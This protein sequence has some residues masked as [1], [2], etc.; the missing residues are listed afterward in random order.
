MLKRGTPVEIALL[1][2]GARGELNLATLAKRHPDK[3]RF[4]AVAEPHEGRR[5][6]FI[7]NFGIPRNR[8]FTGW[9]ELLDRPRLADGVINAL[10]CHMHYDSTLA[11]LAAG[12]HIFLE[13]PMA[14]TPRECIHLLNRARETGRVLMVATQSRYNKIYTKMI[15]QVEE[16]RIG[17]MMNID[18]CEDIGYW[19]FILSYVRGIHHRSDQSHSFII[20]KG[21]H[22]LDLVSWY[23]GAPAKRVA[24]FGRLSFF[25]SENAPPGAAKRCLDDCPAEP[26]C[27]FS[28]RKQFLK[29]GRPDIP[30]SLFGGMSLEALKDVI[31]NPR[32]RTLASV[33]T[34]DI[35]PANR[36]KVLEDT[37]NGQCVFHCDN[38]VVDHQTVSIEFENGVTASFSLSGFSLIWERT[39]NLH[40]TKGELRSKDFSGLLERRTYMPAKVH[41]ERVRFHG[42]IHG[43]GDEII[44]LEFA[45]AVKSGNGD[46]I[47]TGAET[48][49][50]SH[51]ICFAAEEARRQKKVVDMAE[52]RKLAALAKG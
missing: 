48:S 32:F 7:R 15:K 21:I 33:I 46:K 22:D 45:K 13:K 23:A 39:L 4:V 2:A 5:E 17:R 16:G 31:V 43:G 30:I 10:P 25:N 29:P 36:R 26:N 28:A 49:V 24:S 47:L 19:H 11:A 50:E 34:D 37:I 38:D 6:R 9:K 14:H 40:G 27:P 44:L 1:G 41:R 20:A 18:C 12:Y 51:L 52:F 35:S 42:I 3:L 8:A